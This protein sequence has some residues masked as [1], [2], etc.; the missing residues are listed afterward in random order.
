MVKEE[1]EQVIYPVQHIG[2]NTLLCLQ[3]AL[4]QYGNF[5][6]V[7]GSGNFWLILCRVLCFV[8]ACPFVYDNKEMQTDW[9]IL[10]LDLPA[11]TL[12]Q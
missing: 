7:L 2:C 9:E 3:Q 6:F 1:I 10:Q 4:W 8:H 11:A 12:W 5:H